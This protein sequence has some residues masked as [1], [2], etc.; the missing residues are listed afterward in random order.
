MLMFRNRI[1]NI[2]VY[3]KTFIMYSHNVKKSDV[4]KFVKIILNISFQC[5]TNHI[6]LLTM[7]ILYLSLIFFEVS[8]YI[9]YYDL[10]KTIQMN[11]VLNMLFQPVCIVCILLCPHL[12]PLSE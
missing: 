4:C 12:P 3:L 6:H 11:I 8:N 9:K 10:N 2:N 5:F 1:D 7:Q